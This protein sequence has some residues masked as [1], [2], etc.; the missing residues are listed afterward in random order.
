MR[1]GRI[2]NNTIT[3]SMKRRT[4]LALPA[5]AASGMLAGCSSADLGPVTHRLMKDPEYRETLS[6]FLISADGKKLVVIGKQYHYIFDVP[7]ALAVNLT[8]P[9][10]PKLYTDFDDFETHG[11]TISGR[12]VLRLAREDAPP[13][14]ELRERALA[15]GFKD[16]RHQLTD[17]G[18]ISGKRYQPND[19]TPSS[20]PQAFNH[21]Y[22][23]KVI[24]RPS[25]L[26]KGAKLALSPITMAAD[27]AL[28]LLGLALFPIAL[29]AFI[30]I[31][32]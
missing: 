12:Y 3:P 26:G 30:V 24:E 27:G 28:G 8:A 11:D 2:T 32:S 15:D 25:V 21:E 31:A 22:D 4:F 6:A 29:T 10:R 20:L 9:Y 19:V 17:S 16:Q 14:S 7:P 5:V 23:V 13:G 1:F 18:T